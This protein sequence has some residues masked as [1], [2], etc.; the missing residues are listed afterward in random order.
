MSTVVD[1][2]FKNWLNGRRHFEEV[3][4]VYVCVV[5]VGDVYERRMDSVSRI[6]SC[7]YR[8]VLYMRGR[9]LKSRL[10]PLD[11]WGWGV[12]LKACSGVMGVEYQKMYEP[13]GSQKCKKKWKRRLM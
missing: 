3:E 12:G 4:S 5:Y 6:P 7:L 11:A 8:R 13:R 1:D 10:E 2:V 9:K